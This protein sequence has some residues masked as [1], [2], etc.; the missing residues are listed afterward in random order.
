MKA[1]SSAAK[2]WPAAGR[3]EAAGSAIQ[4]QRHA[5]GPADGLYTPMKFVQQV[6]ITL[7]GERVLSMESASRWRPIP[8]SDPLRAADRPASSRHRAERQRQRGVRMRLRRAASGVELR[9]IPSPERGGDFFLIFV[10]LLLCA[11]TSTPDRETARSRWLLDRAMGGPVRRPLRAARSSHAALAALI[12]ERI[13]SGRRGPMPHKPD[14]IARRGVGAAAASHRS[15]AACG[16]RALGQVSFRRRSMPGTRL[17]SEADRRNQAKPLVVFCTPIAG[18]LERRQRAI[19]YGYTTCS[20]TRRRHRRLAGI[21]S[22]D[23]SRA[24]EPPPFLASRL[25]DGSFI[26]MRLVVVFSFDSAI[27][28]FGS[29]VAWR[30]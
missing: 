21:R 11:C 27:A 23:A 29:A 26:W 10:A 12:T 6:E 16:C 1:A 15:Q 13:P 8:R 5:D 17:A 20:G 14:N 4:F 24:A 22:R 18:Q 25:E 19:L 9:W 7:N 28:L 3:G 2:S 30:T